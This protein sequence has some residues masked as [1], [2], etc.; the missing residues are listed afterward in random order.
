MSKKHQTEK[1]YKCTSV[2]PQNNG[3]LKR[4]TFMQML[5]IAKNLYNCPLCSSRLAEADELDSQ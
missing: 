4:C 3:M 1:M 5:P 2:G